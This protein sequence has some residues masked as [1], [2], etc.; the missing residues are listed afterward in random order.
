[1]LLFIDD[2]TRDISIYILRKKSE[3]LSRFKKWKALKE[4]ESGHQLMR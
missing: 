1:M 2:A 4:K 3:A